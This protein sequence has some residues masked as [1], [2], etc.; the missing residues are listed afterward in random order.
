VTPI[1]L[2]SAA[3]EKVW[4]SP[5]TE[6][7]YR[8][9]EGRKIGEIWFAA[10]DSVPLLVKLLFTSDNLSVQV[11]PGDEYARKH[12]SSRGK[13]EMWHILRAQPDS[14]IALGLRRKVTPEHLREA[15]ISGEIM[16]LLN[17][18]PARQGDTFFVPA[19]TIHAIGGGLAL[20]EIQQHSDITYRLYDYGRPRELHLGHAL[21]VANPEP[22]SGTAQLPL[23]CAYFRTE[24]FGVSGSRTVLPSPERNTLYIAL[25]GI[26][27][28]A[29][30]E[31]QAGEAW[32]APAGSR[33]FEIHS[34]AAAFLVT[35]PM[36]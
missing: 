33:P 36:H 16:E 5:E 7:W 32:E 26:G 10:S 30:Q 23:E 19:G 3:H 11:H 29:G 21:A 24:R 35:S 9:S 6:P 12:H 28:I 22:A 13:T 34:H 8:N 2:A 14:R 17:W 25:E 1:K 18:V 4:G 20:C 31:F 15:A 27:S